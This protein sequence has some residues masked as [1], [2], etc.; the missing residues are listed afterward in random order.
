MGTARASAVTV[1]AELGALTNFSFLEGGSHPHELVA[2]AQALGHAAIGVADRN[3]FAGVVRAHV[4]A[5]ADPEKEGTK[6]FPFLPGVRLCLTDG[7]EYL[8][9]PTDRTAWGRL[10]R[11]LSEGRMAARRRTSF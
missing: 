1:F 7:C 5:K 10:T 4:A 6:D 8:A 3:S 2:T 9:W 11:L